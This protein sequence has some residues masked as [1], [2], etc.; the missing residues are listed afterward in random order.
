MKILTIFGSGRNQC[1]PYM[2]FID[3]VELSFYVNQTFLITTFFFFLVNVENSKKP[4][5]NVDFFFGFN[6]SYRELKKKL[7]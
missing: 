1:E 5:K 7:K 6:L 3:P 2:C 4:P